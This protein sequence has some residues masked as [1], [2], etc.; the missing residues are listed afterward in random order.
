[1]Q[2]NRRLLFRFYVTIVAGLIAV[3]ATLDY[4]FNAYQQSSEHPEDRWVAATFAL[5]E[6]RL[7]ATDPAQRSRALGEI[8]AELGHTVELLQLDAVVG[9]IDGDAGGP[10]IVTID[11]HGN[12]VYMYAA[13]TLD[14]VVQLGPVPTTEPSALTNLIPPLF[15][16]SIFVLV[17]W[18]LRPLLRDLT[19]VSESTSEFAAD[20]RQPLTRLGEITSLRDLAG[21]IESMAERIRALIRGQQ[22]LTN[23][24]SHEVRTPLA[25][26][27]FALAVKGDNDE[28]GGASEL[29][30]IHQDVEEIDRLIASML[31]YARLEHGGMETNWQLTPADEWLHATVAKHTASELTIEVDND[32]GAAPVKMDPYLMSLVL[33]NLLVNACRF[34]AGCVQVHLS[35]RD[36]GYALV[37]EDDGPGI[38]ETDYDTVFSAFTRLDASRNK[39]TGGY[40]LGLA[41]VAR[42]SQLHAG[43]ASVD[44]SSLGGARFT[45]SWADND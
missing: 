40:G 44:R 12:A 2:Q 13:T 34:A 16:L 19:I 39:D 21:N 14:A 23:A 20:Y 8:A 38:P 35:R 15:Y 11:D 27:K 4:A 1:M 41:I 45:V 33:S 9:F 28:Q 43:S 5:I 6:R 42:V 30:S 18:W 7:E 29:E 36:G 31:D 24:L 25:R 32:L 22:D 10:P 17:G 37:V 26:I 3:G